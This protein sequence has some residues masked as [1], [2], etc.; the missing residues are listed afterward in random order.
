V[1]KSAHATVAAYIAAQ[2]PEVR[3]VL[4]RLRA[5]IRKAVPE[6]EEVISYQI[7]AYK[8]EGRPVVYF[9]GWKSHVSLYPATGRV[10]SEMADEIAPYRA[11]K[12][13]LK[14]PLGKPIPVRLIG[15]IAKLR[16]EEVREVAAKAKARRR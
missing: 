7:P 16:A 6:A 14:F 12:G 2:P 9:A 13:T 4:E 8:L 3:P 5:I 10:A 1:A 15:R 11:S